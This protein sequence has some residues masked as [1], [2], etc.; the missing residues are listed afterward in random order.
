LPTFD[1]KREMAS[2][3]KPEWPRRSLNWLRIRASLAVALFGVVEAGD[4]PRLS[5]KCPKIPKK[6]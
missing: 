4:T 1:T 3:L 6:H 2:A 5:A